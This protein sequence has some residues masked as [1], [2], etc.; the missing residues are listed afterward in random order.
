MVK[1]IA[2]LKGAIN[3]SDLALKE[4]CLAYEIVFF[5]SGRV[6]HRDSSYAITHIIRWSCTYSPGLKAYINLIEPTGDEPT[7]LNQSLDIPK[8]EGC[9]EDLHVPAPQHVESAPPCTHIEHPPPPP[10][11]RI[12]IHLLG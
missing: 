4:T 3:A 6:I 7:Y 9:E 2:R 12:L 11:L 8:M 10:H 1:T 5:I